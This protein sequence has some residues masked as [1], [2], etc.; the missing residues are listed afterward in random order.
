[1]LAA[2]FIRKCFLCSSIVVFAGLDSKEIWRVE[3][4]YHLVYNM[5]VCSHDIICFTV[6]RITEYKINLSHVV[7]KRY[8]L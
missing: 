5:F 1:M 7:L 6:L 4:S 3:V 8:L 2:S